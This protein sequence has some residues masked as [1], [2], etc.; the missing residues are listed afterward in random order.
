MFVEQIY[1]LAR[2]LDTRSGVVLKSQ[3]TKISA[4]WPMFPDMGALKKN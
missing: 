4:L 1:F 3:Y 2:K